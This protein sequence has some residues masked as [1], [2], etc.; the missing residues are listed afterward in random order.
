MKWIK[1]ISA[2]F[3]MLILFGCGKYSFTTTDIGN[4]KTFQVT[5]FEN[6]ARLVEPG[7][8]TDF[9]ESLRNLLVNQTQ[10]N[11]VNTAGDLT[12]EGEIIE[13]Q[14]SPTSA[15]SN[16]RATQ[17]RLSM[18]VNVR[19]FNTLDEQ[20]NFEKSFSFFFDYDGSSL[21]QGSLKNTAHEEIFERLTQDIFNESLASSF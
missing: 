16:N 14:I 2:F 17:N 11:L 21:L 12:Y 4:A 8:D 10:L 18:T 20:K 19:F 15:N 7:I 1:H 6:N 13:Y 3:L 9:T 5:L